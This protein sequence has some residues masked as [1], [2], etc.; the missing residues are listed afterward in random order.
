[1]VLELSNIENQI[2]CFQILK[3]GPNKGQPCGC[4]IF[5]DNFCK[6]HC[7]KLIL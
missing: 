1:M 7:K 3:T 2:G 6:R 5:T 4:K